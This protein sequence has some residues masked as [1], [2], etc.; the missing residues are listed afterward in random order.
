MAL[1]SEG[2]GNFDER[3]MFP[4]WGLRM[5]VTGRGF[6]RIPYTPVIP[7]RGVFERAAQNAR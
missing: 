2:R 3:V 7:K 5:A 4:I 6:G 1:L